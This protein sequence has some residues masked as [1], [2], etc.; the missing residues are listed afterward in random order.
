MISLRSCIKHSKEC[1][2][3]YPNTLKWV[4][5]YSAALRFSTHFFVFEY[6]DETLFLVFDILL[7]DWRAL[8]CGHVIPYMYIFACKRSLK[9]IKG[10]YA[11]LF[12]FAS[13]IFAVMFFR[14]TLSSRLFWN[15]DWNSRNYSPTK[16]SNNTVHT[17]HTFKTAK[18]LLT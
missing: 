12:N 15:L 13:L 10:F 16:I 7:D 1:C 14:G 17:I 5:K 11:K 6:P 8:D 4:K 18:R 9:F 3:S 2:I